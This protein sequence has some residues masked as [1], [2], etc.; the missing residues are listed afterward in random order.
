MNWRSIAHSILNPVQTMQKRAARSWLSIHGNNDL[1]CQPGYT[2]L[3]DNPEVQTAVYKIADLVSSQTIHLME[4]TEDGDIRIKDGLARK[5]DVNPYSLTTRKT[6]IHTIVTAMLLEGE[7]NSV[8]YPKTSNGLVEDLIPLEPSK[9]NFEK[10]TQG[11][12]VIY[13]LNTVYPHDEVLHFVA[14]PDPSS[15]W[16]GRGF[17]VHLKRVVEDLAQAGATRSGFL[18]GKYMPSLI[19]RVDGQVD[20]LTTEEGKNAVYE[21]Y[22]T[23]HEAGAP[24]I[25]PADLL[26]VQQVKPLSLTDLALHDSVQLDKKMVAGIFGIPPFVLGVGEFNKDEF[27]NFIRTTILPITKNIEQELTRKLLISPDR[28]FK[29]NARSL[30]AYDI[31][32]L[33]N[34]GGDLYTKGIM[35]GNEVRDWLGMSPVKALKD[36]IMLE[37]YIPADQI[38]EQSK[39]K[40]GENE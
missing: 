14:N 31:D 38:G 6:F 29:M 33:A 4:N 10:T 15:P 13:N 36:H 23:A 19:V 40:G 9:I 26:D 16:K 22:L 3:K 34:V 30:Y 8:V 17:R 5:I 24:W 28:Y 20:E 27:N 18:K 39:L 32:M 1:L 21:K 11:Y 7:G 25:V 2:S 37:N 35:T 12:N